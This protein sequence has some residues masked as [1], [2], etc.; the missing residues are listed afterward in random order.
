[1][2]IQKNEGYVTKSSQ[3]TARLGEELARTLKVTEGRALGKNA[4]TICLYGELGSGK[5]TFT[6][7]FA[8]GFGITSRL[9]SPTYIIVRRYQLK[10]PFSFF[11]HID[12]YRIGKEQDLAALGVSEILSDPR[13]VISVEWA[14]KLG[15]LLPKKRI[16]IHFKGEDDGK[17]TVSITEGH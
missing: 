14:E 17:H 12:L 6:Q 16:D 13:S 1:M 7:G 2:N 15:P 10:K 9:L 3:E 4:T 8:K 11:Y 5:T